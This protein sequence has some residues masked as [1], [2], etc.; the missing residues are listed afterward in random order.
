MLSMIN[1]F[2]FRF[3]PARDVFAALNGHDVKSVVKTACYLMLPRDDFAL[4]IAATQQRTS[5]KTSAFMNSNFGFCNL[6][7]S[8][9]PFSASFSSVSAMRAR[10]AAALAPRRRRA[11]AADSE[12]IFPTCAQA[13]PASPAWTDN[14][15]CR[16]RCSR[17][18]DRTSHVQSDK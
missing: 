5:L 2:C 3:S 9:A 10:P 6:S 1:Y 12:S 15:S 7:F 4:A 18:A 17:P 16:I 14:H 13:R 11:R 8:V